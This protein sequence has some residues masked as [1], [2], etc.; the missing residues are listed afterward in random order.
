MIDLDGTLV[1]SEYLHF[2]STA[3]VLATRGVIIDRTQYEMYVGWDERACWLSLNERFGLDFD[4]DVAV[5]KRTHA[6]VE[7]LR[8][9]RLDVLPGA[10]ELLAWAHERGLPM[11]VVSSLPHDQ[12]DASL[13]AA[14]LDR[15]LP[16]RRSG[17]DDVPPGRGKPAPD[18]YLAAAAALGVDPR[19]CFACEDSPTG[20]RS[21]RAAGCYVIGI[22][23]VSHPTA[24]VSAA[25]MICGSLADVMSFLRECTA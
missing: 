25:D 1:D 3:A 20:M 5:L 2:E 19:D 16:L 24:D 18:V 11:A 14:N 10:P 9:R 22:P 7:L 15:Y 13:A 21:A 17:H 4:P 12:I 8:G 6:Y 23:C